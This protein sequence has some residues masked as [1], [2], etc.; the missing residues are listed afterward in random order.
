[1]QRGSETRSVTTKI[2]TH[3]HTYIYI[4]IYIY[5]YTYIY[6]YIY[7]DPT[8]RTWARIMGVVQLSTAPIVRH[9]DICVQ[10]CMVHK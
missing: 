4:H 5:I 6:I 7:T 2:H 1:M 9:Y 3:T 10:I 8:L